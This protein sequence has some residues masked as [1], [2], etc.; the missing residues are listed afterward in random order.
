[1]RTARQATRRRLGG[2]FVVGLAALTPFLM[3]GCPDYR[4][5]VVDTFEE[6]TRS[7][8]SGSDQETV[9]ANAQYGFVDA[10]V[11]LFFDQFRTDDY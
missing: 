5:A 9:R 1:M 6:A 4:N 2:L 7:Y 11:T 3:G 10:T 8:L